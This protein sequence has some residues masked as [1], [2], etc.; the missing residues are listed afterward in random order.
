MEKSDLST[1]SEKKS[2][3]SIVDAESTNLATLFENTED[4]SLVL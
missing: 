4:S 2:H 1:L 3:P